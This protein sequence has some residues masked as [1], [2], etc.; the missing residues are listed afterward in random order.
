MH[1]QHYEPRAQG[2]DFLSGLFFGALA[3]AAVG[4]LFAPRSGAELRGRVAD[5]AGRLRR[6]AERAYDDASTLVH[7]AVDCGRDAI[8]KG[9]AEFKE[10]AAKVR[11]EVSDVTGA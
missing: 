1:E 3:G 2:R 5:S 6:E 10:R 4:I 11:A 9:R 7:D 8:Q